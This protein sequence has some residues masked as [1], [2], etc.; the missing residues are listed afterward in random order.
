MKPLLKPIVIV[1]VTAFLM[2]LLSHAQDK[3]TVRVYDQAHPLIYEDAMDL[4][5][6]SFLD[7]DRRTGYNVELVRLL[8]EKLNIPHSIRLKERREVLKDIKEGKADLTTGMD[9][10]FHDEY[11]YY[12]KTI[13]QLFTHSVVTPKNKPVRIRCLDDLQNQRVIVHT[14]SF[15][16]HV[17]MNR[18]WGDNAIP[19]E[20]MVEA[21]QDV[22]EMGEG[23]VVWNTASL[24]WIINKNGLKNLQI[25][26]VDMAHGEYKFISRDPQ[27]L[28][29]LDSVFIEVNSTGLLDDLQ[30]QWMHPEYSETGI[31]SWIWWLTAIIGLGALVLIYQT[32]SFRLQKKH[33]MKV[34]KRNKKRL[35]IILKSS[36]V[37]IWTY[38]LTTLM[39]TWM[40]KDGEPERQYT[41]LE[42]ARRYHSED[43]RRIGESI[44]ELANESTKEISLNIRAN[45]KI[46]GVEQEREYT[47]VLSV[48]HYE[49]GKPKVIIGTKIDVTEEKKRQNNIKNRMQ[50][51]QSIFETALV[52]M[53][54]FD[55]DGNVADM[56]ERAK[57]SFKATLEDAIRHKANVTNCMADDCYKLGDDFYATQIEGNHYGIKYYE[58]QL[59]PIRTSDGRLLGTFGSGRDV[60]EVVTT[61]HELQK[62]ITMLRESNKEVGEY[63]NNINFVLNASGVRIA[64]Y[65][66][67]NHTMTIYRALNVVQL[68]LT[69]TRC[70]T[71]VN[72]KSK[73]TAMRMLNN[74][75]NRVNSIIDM[76][77]KTTLQLH[78][79]PFYVHLRFVPIT[80]ASGKVVNYYGMCRDT[81]EVRN[82]QRLLEIETAHAQEIEDLKNSF[83]R[84][85]SYEIRTP[86]TSVVG[87]ADLLEQEHDPAD[88]PLFIEEI[89]SNSAHLLR[90]IND[91]LF[92]SRLD[93]HMIEMNKQSIDFAQ[94]FG[95]YCQIGWSNYMKPTVKYIVENPYERLIVDIDDTN[96][97]RIIEQITANAAQYTEHGTVRAR[98]D[99]VGG[100]L[101]IAIDDTGA[102]MSSETLSHIYER[103]SSGNNQGTGLGLPIC[104]QLAEQ[105]GGTIEISSE[106]GKGTTVW[107]TMPCTAIKI[108]RKNQL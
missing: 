90:L 78:G 73:K 9:A 4:Y 21:L 13:I 42:F 8:L 22:N 70:M 43:F 36:H 53:V 104:K 68:K 55:A 3:D 87:F 82:T 27:L 77:V 47:I 38:D 97:G 88:E 83:L 5:P 39:F 69:Q 67:D 25:T 40:N 17:M 6:Y 14:N 19:Y 61:F 56:N 72:D 30:K 49:E 20:D 63:V 58:R 106:V 65:S 16:H 102:G 7:N 81:S 74:M 48:L 84:N 28:K 75:D 105:M 91:I 33:M 24:K 57:C 100:K 1:I 37:Q 85:M 108:D 86:L 29:L 11:G 23:Q 80:D 60:T 98:Y 59:V 96:M 50:R 66:P 71:L 31:P 62:G 64:E 34:A 99:Y 76:E 15:S 79:M 18:G 41:G 2:P 45:E 10:L 94:T 51:Y 26:P 103:F 46:D 107:I 35:S 32:L 12:G 95:G 101:M 92:L 44:R 89:K 54:Y 93:A 52:D